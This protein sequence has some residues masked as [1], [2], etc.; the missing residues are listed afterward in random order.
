MRDNRKVLSKFCTHENALTTERKVDY[1][2]FSQRT[3]HS[4]NAKA[5]THDRF[6]PDDEVLFSRSFAMLDLPLI[7]QVIYSVHEMSI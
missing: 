1:R 7:L 2:N 5:V 6:I 3:V 4:L